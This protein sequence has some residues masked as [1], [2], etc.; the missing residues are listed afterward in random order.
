MRT[1][2][3]EKLQQVG[4]QSLRFVR[5]QLY[6]ALGPAGLNLL[7]NNPSPDK[8]KVYV[9]SVLVNV[10]TASITSIPQDVKF[11]FDL[12]QN[13]VDASVD[14]GFDLGL[15]L[16]ALDLQ[17]KVRLQVGGSWHVGLGISRG[18]GFYIDTSATDEL[19]YAIRAT[20]ENFQA[21]GTLGFLQIA[22]TDHA[23]ADE[24][25]R[26]QLGGTFTVDLKGG[27][28]NK[29]T[30]GEIASLSFEQMVSA[31]FVGGAHVDLDIRTTFAGN[32]A[33]P[34]LHTEFLLDWQFDTAAVVQS[35]PLVGFINNYLDAGSAINNIVAPYLKELKEVLGPIGVASDI[36]TTPIPL[37]SELAGDG[38]TLL[39]VIRL[40][41][42]VFVGPR[43]LES[44]E[45]VIRAVDKVLD[46]LK[47]VN[48]SGEI[49]SVPPTST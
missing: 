33:L 28:D 8:I 9:D 17:G 2:T 47:F 39:R 48:A 36:L 7:G 34:N 40:V 21:T 10:D 6:A 26:S 18:D 14:V 22:A 29:L 23:P 30:V 27:G 35:E 46:L 4:A 41:A 13:L 43:T 1:E 11:V 37:V 24:R 5:D 32:S 38:F 49:Q 44:A 12:E 31:R 15:P 3:K 42:E 45:A 16:L 19:T 20:L 25:L